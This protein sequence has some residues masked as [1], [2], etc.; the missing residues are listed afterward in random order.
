[1][2][3]T[4]DQAVETLQ[5]CDM[6]I[7]KTDP[8]T[9]PENSIPVPAVFGLKRS[10]YTAPGDRLALLAYSLSGSPLVKHDGTYVTDDDEFCPF[11]EPYDDVSIN[12]AGHP[13]VADLPDIDW[14]RSCWVKTS[15]RWMLAPLVDEL[16]ITVVGTGVYGLG[17][18]TVDLVTFADVS[19]IPTLE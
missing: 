19:A 1:M 16:G 2:A 15:K 9:V 5:R 3:C 13:D 7:V 10:V 18:E 14:T 8:K 17:Y 6:L 12:L 11:V 4:I